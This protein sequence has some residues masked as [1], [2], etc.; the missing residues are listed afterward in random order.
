MSLGPIISFSSNCN[1]STFGICFLAQNPPRMLSALHHQ[2]KVDLSF[3]KALGFGAILI[4]GINSAMLL[5]TKSISLFCKNGIIIPICQSIPQ[6]FSESFLCPI[7]MRHAGVQWSVGQ[8]QYLFSC[9][10]EPDEGDRQWKQ[11]CQ[12]C[13]VKATA[14]NTAFSSG[15]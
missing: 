3:S 1:S 11:Q 8:G 7:A 6:T 4:C 2:K 15:T 10:A 12:A 9:R 14:G 5:W 13:S